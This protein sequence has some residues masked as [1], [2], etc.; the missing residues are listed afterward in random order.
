MDVFFDVQRRI[1]LHNP[2][3]LWNVQASCCNIGTQKDSF[4]HQAELME[5]CGSFLLLL[6]AVDVH[7][8][9]VNVV[10]QI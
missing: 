6:L 2:V 5:G 3:Y 7:D 8:A 9:D 1:E 4:L 10:Q